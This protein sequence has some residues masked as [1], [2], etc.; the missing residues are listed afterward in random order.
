MEIFRQMLNDCI[1]IGLQLNKTSMKSLSLASYS[2]LKRYQ[3]LSC[4]K[5]CA[6]PRAAGIL[7]NYR[8]LLKKGKKIRKPYCKKAVLTTCYQI[9]IQKG[10]LIL[11]SDI[12][13]PLNDY[14]LK[15]LQGTKIHSVTVSTRSVSIA[16]APPVSEI[17]EPTG[18]IGADMNY[19]NITCADTLG[20]I[21]RLP[22]EEIAETKL[23]YREVKSH[24]ARNDVRIESEINRKYGKLQAD[25]TISEI[26]KH[27]TRLIKHAKK[28]HLAV[29]IEEEIKDIRKLYQRGNGQRADYRFKLNAWARGE[30]KRQLIYKGNREGVSVFSVSARGTSKECS[31]CGDKEMIPE[32]NRISYCPKCNLRIDRDVNAAMNIHKRGLEKLFS[33]RFSP[34]ALSDETMK[35]NP[36]KKLTTEV[37]L[38]ADGSELGQLTQ[39]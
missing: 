4:Y 6:I 20:N 16:F 14:V 27:T 33:K 11:P 37:I 28:H 17:V 8:K 19:E 2:K 25:K 24:F 32:E 12:C 30:A 38:R 36:M 18:V 5:V 7:S 22:M 31:R 34:V 29:A 26:G 21:V 13:I 39:P 23:K 15:K 1:R 35:G 3:I 9:R 10:A